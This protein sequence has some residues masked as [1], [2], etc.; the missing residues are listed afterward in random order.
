M[1]M[2]LQDTA[3]LNDLFNSWKSYRRIGR[4]LRFDEADISKGFF[5]TGSF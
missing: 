4:L 5:M 3:S 1:E 2:Y